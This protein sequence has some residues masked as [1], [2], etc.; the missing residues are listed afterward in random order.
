MFLLAD[1]SSYYQ[2]K[3]MKTK[4]LC[5]LHGAGYNHYGYGHKQRT[6]TIGP[7]IVTSIDS[8]NDQL[9]GLD[10]ADFKARSKKPRS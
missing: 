8:L 9:D 1:R 4:T 2:V 10:L 3:T 5:E 7:K 6:C